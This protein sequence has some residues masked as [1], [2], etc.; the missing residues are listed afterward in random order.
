MSL[1]TKDFRTKDLYLAAFLKARG[2][3]L[4][5]HVKSRGQ[6]FFCFENNGNIKNLKI[7]YFSRKGEVSALQFA[8]E[9]KALK[10]LCHLH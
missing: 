1:M 5:D 4:V 9:V 2:C 10:T 8:D 3:L 6:S 7:Q